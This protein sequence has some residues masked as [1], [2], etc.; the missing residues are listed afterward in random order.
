VLPEYI[1]ATNKN[2]LEIEKMART[3]AAER[4]QVVASAVGL[5]PGHLYAVA[6]H[7][8]TPVAI[9]RGEPTFSIALRKAALET[10]DRDLVEAG[11]LDVKTG[12]PTEKLVME[13]SWEREEILPTPGVLVKGCLDK[14]N[15][16]E[17]ALQNE[18]E[19]DLERKRLDNGM[20]KRQIELLEK[21]Q[22]YRC[23]PSGSE[24]AE[25]SPDE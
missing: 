7:G 8:A 15:T 16:C 23:C 2:R 9:E 24:E 20:L 5:T 12:K 1:S 17:P 25:E 22:E 4:Q 19:L 6:A 10:V 21:S 11:L 3:S 18:I 14:C 13:L